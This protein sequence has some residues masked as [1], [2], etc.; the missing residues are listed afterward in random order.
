[1]HRTVDVIGSGRTSLEHR[2][3]FRGHLLIHLARAI[4]TSHSPTHVWQ[5]GVLTSSCWPTSTA[6]GTACFINVKGKRRESPDGWQHTGRGGDHFEIWKEARK[7]EISSQTEHLPLRV[8]GVTRTPTSR[9][10]NSCLCPSSIFS[11]ASFASLCFPQIHWWCAHQTVQLPITA[12]LVQT[13]A[14]GGLTLML[15]PTAQLTVRTHGP[16]K[17]K[18]AETNKHPRRGCS[19]R[20]PPPIL[21]H[22]RVSACLKLSSCLQI[23]LPAADTPWKAIQLTTPC[24]RSTPSATSNLTY[25]HTDVQRHRVV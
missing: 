4:S 20:L 10:G 25:A 19:P 1:M 21:T 5:R 2:N 24:P 11:S 16:S 23:K 6:H 22:C 13:S 14:S 17:S 3:P 18:T 12:R 15:S 9:L 7:A 8:T